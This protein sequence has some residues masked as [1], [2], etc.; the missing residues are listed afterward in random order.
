M[1][2]NHPSSPALIVL[3]WQR[4]LTTVWLSPCRLFNLCWLP[5]INSFETIKPSHAHQRP[6][7]PQAQ[8]IKCYSNT[9]LAALP[10]NHVGLDHTLVLLQLSKWLE[11]LPGYI[12]PTLRSSLWIPKTQ[13][14]GLLLGL[15]I[16]WNSNCQNVPDSASFSYLWNNGYAVI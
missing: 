2:D 8:E 12:T 15:N 16:P 5:S 10:L 7:W 13:I 9:V 4:L 11:N 3:I 6:F 14:S 1:R